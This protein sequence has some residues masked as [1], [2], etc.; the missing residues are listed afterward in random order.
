MVV[1]GTTLDGELVEVIELPEHA[2][3]VGVQCHPE[4]KS[5]PTRAHPLF[6]DF[7]AA[8]LAYKAEKKAGPDRSSRGREMAG[9]GCSG[10]LLLARRPIRRC[11]KKLSCAFL[12]L[13]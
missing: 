12:I 2:W 9:G 7:V 1:A 4:F 11:F 5:K 3:F 13:T 8:G 6:R 10:V